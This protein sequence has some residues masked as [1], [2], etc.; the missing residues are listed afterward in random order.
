[1]V[2]AN[3]ATV[4]AAWANVTNLS[5]P[6]LISNTTNTSFLFDSLSIPYINVLSSA[7]ILSSNLLL[8]NI[9]VANVT[10]LN[11]TSANISVGNIVSANLSTANILNGNVN[12]L[13]IRGIPIFLS[14]LAN[15]VGNV[16]VSGNLISGN[17]I[18][19][20]LIISQNI[21]NTVGNVSVFGNLLVS[22]N[23]YSGGLVLAPLGYVSGMILT[24][25]G[26]A[27]IGTATMS[28]GAWTGTIAG[29]PTNN[30]Y[31]I[32]LKTSWI[33]TTKSSAITITANGGIQ[34]GQVGGYLI[35]A[36]LSADN[37]MRTLALTSNTSGSLPPFTTSNWTYMYRYSVTQDPSYQI[38]IPV[39]V[40][41]TSTVYFID[42]ELNVQGDN[43]HQTAY[44]ATDLR[45]GTFI[46]IMPV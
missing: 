29:T 3:I 11:V 21:S 17:L 20:N 39:V 37:N 45:T 30:L 46:T 12:S 9:V 44:S 28:S 33:Q 4:N 31:T 24:L 35:S 16:A 6:G 18:T 5:T 42:I 7:N 1:V 23:T 26:T 38:T 8:C 36:I 25:A 40:T 10:T 32:L 41:S 34:F 14:N 43:I 19:T 22:Q 27:T 13:V 2:S 15:A